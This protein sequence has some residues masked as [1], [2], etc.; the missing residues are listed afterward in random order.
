VLRLIDRSHE[1]QPPVE[2]AVGLFDPKGT[3]VSAAK[4]RTVFA[5]VR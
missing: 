2:E 5:A 4:A 1:V 3:I